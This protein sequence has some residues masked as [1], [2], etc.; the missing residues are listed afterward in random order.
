MFSAEPPSGVLRSQEDVG[1]FHWSGTQ[2]GLKLSEPWSKIG[3]RVL[4]W[5]K[6]GNLPKF[7]DWSEMEDLPDDSSH[8]G[9]VPRKDSPPLESEK[10]AVGPGVSPPPQ[11]L[12]PPRGV[13]LRGL[14]ALYEQEY[15]QQLITLVPSHWKRHS[16]LAIQKIGI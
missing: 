13:A 1:H 3:G 11:R 12:L 7:G 14:P 8:G 2:D 16:A 6:S 10:K 9:L 4:P 15:L 5:E